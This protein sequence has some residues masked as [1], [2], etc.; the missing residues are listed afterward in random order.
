MVPKSVSK[1]D[2]ADRVA[3]FRQDLLQKK[4][5]TVVSEH[6]LDADPFIF[7][8][9]RETYASLVR[10]L[11]DGLSVA[12]GSIVAV[13]SAKLGFSVHPDKFPRPFGSTS[14]IDMAVIDHALFDRI[15]HAII[16]WHYPRKGETLP[17]EE[18]EWVRQRRRDIYWGLF[19]PDK[20]RFR[21]LTFPRSLVPLRDISTSWFNAFR[22]ASLSTGLTAHTISGRLYRSRE[23]AM[24]Y[25]A[26]GLRRIR[27]AIT[28]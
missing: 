23:H 10:E 12:Q 2:V 4:A 9:E 27:A 17:P 3:E 5:A 25:Q 8:D 28:Q 18:R 19:H 7:S 20:I 14:D 1:A 22:K 24:K 16:D 26:A 21:G 13:G 15:W 6:I 11:S